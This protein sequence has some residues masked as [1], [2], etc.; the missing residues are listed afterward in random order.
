MRI[1]PRV[2]AVDVGTG[3][4]QLGN[5]PRAVVVDVRPRGVRALLAEL[6][7][8]TVAETEAGVALIARRCALDEPD[9]L[10][11]LEGLAPVLEGA[12]AEVEG[13]EDTGPD[14]VAVEAAGAGSLPGAVQVD[15]L[16]RTGTAVAALLASAGI[17]RIGLT[18]L[19]PVRPDELG[20][21][22]VTADIGRPRAEALAQRLGDRGVT[23]VACHP[24]G[25]RGVG[26]GP[27][28]VSVTDGA[29]DVSR[30]AR[31]QAAGQAVLPVVLRDEDTLVGPWCAPATP[32]CP[33]CWERWAEREDPLRAE[34]T[35]A[36][37]RA[38]A[39]R[40]PVERA[41]RT[42]SVVLAVLRGGPVPG[43]AWRV[44]DS[45]AGGGDVETVVGN[46]AVEES[47]AAWPGCGCGD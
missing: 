5:G 12:G 25:R 14:G 37:L 42:A 17:P 36:L 18:D 24:G 6:T 45:A 28:S 41:Q 46:D 16:G 4:V 10:R 32:G 35:S 9:V 8:G 23:A 1:D 21:G 39:C 40:D 31:A 47:V 13:A 15:G 26:T 2:S 29:W 34:R 11:L 38:E 7:T 33:L 43:L 3:Q 44:R 20:H 19:R 27:V 22:L 30:L